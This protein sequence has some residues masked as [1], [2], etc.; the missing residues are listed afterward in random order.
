[1]NTMLGLKNHCADHPCPRCLV[2]KG[3]LLST[4]A[5]KRKRGHSLKKHSF[6]S[7]DERLIVIDPSRI[8]PSPVHL[9]LGF[10]NRY[11]KR[12][13][14][15][16]GEEA[17]N[18][19]IEKYRTLHSAGHGGAGDLYALNGPELCKCLDRGLGAK[20][21]KSLET[22]LANES[23]ESSSAASASLSSSSSTFTID[24][25]LDHQAIVEH[26][27]RWMKQLKTQ[28][29][30]ANDWD[31]QDIKA[32]RTLVNEI[33]TRWPQFTNTPAFP[34]LHMLQH[35]HEFASEHGFL[36]RA[37]EAQVESFHQTWNYLYQKQHRNMSHNTPERIRRCLADSVLIAVQ[38]L[39]R[40]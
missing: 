31:R 6:K 14:Q 23:N 32:W 8:V 27:E 28:L 24:K 13:V 36:G 2:Y 3:N 7:V 19:A 1:M 15:L 10:G 35:T 34:K 4:K 38:P 30:H 17:V 37:S 20:L 22:K 33:Q 11:V 16:F 5:A 18:E 25:S 12:L 39:L 40:E 26:L 29:L 21:L 9:F